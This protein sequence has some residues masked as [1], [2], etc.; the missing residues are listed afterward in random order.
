[1]IFQTKDANGAPNG[2]LVTV[3]DK[4]NP[5]HI[6]AQVYVTTVYPDCSKG[7]HLHY[8]R[9]GRF[10]CLI[11]EV[12][13]ITRKNGVYETTV[14]NASRGYLDVPAGVAAKIVNRKLAE[15]YVISMPSGVFDP[16]DE[17]E[18]EGWNPCG[19]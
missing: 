9:A 13:I 14:L 15:A 1:M 3:W 17:W 19:A 10:F 12:A 6:P 18:V 4:S 7:P 11:G 2:K 16:D 5:G 8:Q